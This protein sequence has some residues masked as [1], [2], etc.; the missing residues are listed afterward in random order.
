MS[1]I[2]RASAPTFYCVW[3]GEGGQ[4]VRAGSLPLSRPFSRSS[5]LHR[6]YRLSRCVAAY[7]QR[8]ISFSYVEFGIF[9][10]K[11]HL[12]ALRLLSSIR[13][14]LGI[15]VQRSAWRARCMGFL[16]FFVHLR[17]FCTCQ[18]THT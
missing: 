11:R 3:I 12:Q 1:L 14:C 9:E 4:G 15:S 17:F 7:R 6:H 18:S 10:N 5:F 2:P 16:T 13:T 8:N